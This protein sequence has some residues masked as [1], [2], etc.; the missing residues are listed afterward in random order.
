MATS[1]TYYGATADT[2]KAYLTQWNVQGSTIGGSDLLTPGSGSLGG[3]FIDDAAA[4][5]AQALMDGGFGETV[6]CST[7]SNVNAY[8]RLRTLISRLAALIWADSHQSMFPNLDPIN[9]AWARARKELEEIASGNDIGEVSVGSQ[10]RKV[11][12]FHH[13]DNESDDDHDDRRFRAINEV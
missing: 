13:N 2:V 1:P 5:V 4:M 11:A 9:G 6:S 3:Q 7:T 10:S 8:L 12:H